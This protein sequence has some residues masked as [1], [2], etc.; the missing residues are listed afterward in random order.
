MKNAAD[1]A[2]KVVEIINMIATDYIDFSSNYSDCMVGMGER[3]VDYALYI[4]DLSENYV[5]IIETQ[6]YSLLDFEIRSKRM[7]EK[8]RNEEQF[9]FLYPAV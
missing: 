8:K 7:T 4:V 1:I 9:E 6:G 3:E 2:S 5:L